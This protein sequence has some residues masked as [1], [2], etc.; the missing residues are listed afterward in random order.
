MK[1]EKWVKRK[2]D[3]KWYKVVKETESSVMIEDIFEFASDPLYRKLT[4]WWEKEFC[5]IIEVH[6][7]E[8]R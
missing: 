6:K 3:N 5:D 2:M 1:K 8:Y 7:G 4:M